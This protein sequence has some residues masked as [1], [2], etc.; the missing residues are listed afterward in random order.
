MANK[1]HSGMSGRRAGGQSWC[2]LAPD[3]DGMSEPEHRAPKGP[4]LDGCRVRRLWPNDV[5]NPGR[6]RQCGTERMSCAQNVEELAV[7][8]LVR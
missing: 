8:L 2:T 7:E 5:R 1:N 3:E 4:R 6:G